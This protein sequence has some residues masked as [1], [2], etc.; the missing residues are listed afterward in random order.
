VDGAISRVQGVSLLNRRMFQRL[1]RDSEVINERIG[2][3]TKSV[4]AIYR[5]AIDS[6]TT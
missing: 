1:F 5:E 4:F 6:D 2:S 3:L